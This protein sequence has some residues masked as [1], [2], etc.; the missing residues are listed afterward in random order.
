MLKEMTKTLGFVLLS[1]GV[2]SSTALSYAIS[3]VGQRNTRCLAVNYGQR[4]VKEILHA[5]KVAA[6]YGRSLEMLKIESMP[7]A[8]LTDPSHEIP[9]VSYA[10]LPHGISPTYVPFRN[11][12]FLS[13]AAGHIQA[14][15]KEL[16]VAETGSASQ[17]SDTNAILYFGAH[18]EDSQNWAYPDCTPEFSGAMANAIYVGTYCRV[19][20][21]VPWQHFMKADIIAWGSKQDPQTPYHLTWSCYRG[22]NLHCGTC[23]TCRSRKDAFNTAGVPDPTDYADQLSGPEAA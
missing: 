5:G 9:D 7:K 20:L 17:F 22:L 6:F 1:G 2:D 13:L 19:R 10:D 15:L 4:H 16:D 21:C 18:A 14:H 8:M 23:P 3:Q 11:G 12:Q